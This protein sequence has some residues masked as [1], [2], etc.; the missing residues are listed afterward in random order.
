VLLSRGDVDAALADFAKLTAAIHGSFSAEGVVVDAV[1][2][3]TLFQRAGLRAGD[4]I[5]AVDGARLRSLDDA[6]NLYA[7][8][9]KASTLTAQIVRGG[10][11]MTL[12]VA[13]R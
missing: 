10:K 12:H 4:V 13:I 9:A 1:G 11:A 2:E 6:A 7:R 3:G 8:A 5:A